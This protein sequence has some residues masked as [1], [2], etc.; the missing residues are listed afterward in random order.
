MINVSDSHQTRTA[1]E[2]DTFNMEDDILR[3]RMERYV[4][5]HYVSHESMMVVNEAD[6]DKIYDR[7][8]HVI[9]QSRIKTLDSTSAHIELCELLETEPKTQCTMCFYHNGISVYSAARD[10]SYT[11][12]K[13]PTNNS[14]IL[15]WTFFQS[16]SMSSGTGRPR[17]FYG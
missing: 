2:S 14:S 13:G 3:E 1:H 7:I 9:F 4:V 15:R 6:M 5:D 10:I 16:L 12:K 11:K 17:I 8:N